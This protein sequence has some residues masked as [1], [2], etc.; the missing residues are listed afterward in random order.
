MR[1]GKT[2]LA[3]I[4]FAACLIL[5]AA[6]LPGLAPP[7][8]PAPVLIFTPAAPCGDDDF[9]WHDFHARRITLARLEQNP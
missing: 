2:P 4:L 5:A 7:P 9:D 8:E 6:C 3:P 1:R